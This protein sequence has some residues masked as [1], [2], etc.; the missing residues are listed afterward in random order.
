M[1][2][3]CTARRYHRPT[4]LTLEEHHV[5]PQAWQRF[6]RPDEHDADRTLAQRINHARGVGLPDHNM[7]TVY[8]WDPRTVTLCPTCHR[9]VHVFIKELMKAADTNDP[10]DSMV[11]RFGGRR[12]TKEQDIAY[13]A[14]CRYRAAGGDLRML[15]DAKLWGQA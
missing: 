11:A 2:R 12:L 8:L 6:W 7:E 13:L 14:L 10:L 1:S 5:V 15:R 4:P 3:S 9:N